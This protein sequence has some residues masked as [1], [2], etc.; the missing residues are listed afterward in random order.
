MEEVEGVEDFGETS[1]AGDGGFVGG[2]VVV[3]MMMMIASTGW[4]G[5]VLGWWWSWRF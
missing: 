4:R 5:R 1:L 2:V 3:V